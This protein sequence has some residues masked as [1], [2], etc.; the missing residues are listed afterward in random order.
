MCS[1]IFG[2]TGLVLS[3]DDP[4]RFL[5]CIQTTHGTLP[6]HFKMTPAAESHVCRGTNFDQFGPPRHKNFPSLKGVC[7][8]FQP[9][10]FR[11]KIHAH[12]RLANHSLV[13][14]NCNDL[15][16]IARVPY[17]LVD[18]HFKDLMVQ[19]VQVLEGHGVASLR[20]SGGCRNK[21]SRG[22]KYQ[23]VKVLQV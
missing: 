2:T 20:R 13:S 14:H 5:F 22:S 3:Q 19:K 10:G 9:E 12:T 11:L 15:L 17:Q 7:V 1:L 21:K 16:C 23:K 4:H 6:L 8:Y 18:A